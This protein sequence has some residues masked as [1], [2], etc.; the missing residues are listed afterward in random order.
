MEQLA[1][2]TLTL[3][4]ECPVVMALL[5]RAQPSLWRRWLAGLLP[6]LVTHPLAWRAV[7]GLG[8]QDQW[9]GWAV[10]E[11]VVAV[12]EAILITPLA[13]VRPRRAMLTSVCTNGLSAA[14]GLLSWMAQA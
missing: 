12:V 7:H 3:A 8:P 13:G 2:F 11:L 14:V 1:A 5:A 9:A 4:I 10:V 6:S